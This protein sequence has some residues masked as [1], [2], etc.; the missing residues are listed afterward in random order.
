MSVENL[1]VKVYQINLSAGAAGIA[2]IGMPRTGES[3]GG[4][5]GS[6]CGDGGK[7]VSS[8]ARSR[9]SCLS[10][11]QRQERVAHG[12][13]A[14]HTV[15]R[16]GGRLPLAVACT[17]DAHQTVPP[18]L[19]RGSRLAGPRT[20]RRPGYFRQSCF[21]FRPRRTVDDP[22]AAT[23]CG[24]TSSTCRNDPVAEIDAVS[25]MFTNRGLLEIAIARIMPAGARIWRSMGPCL[26]PIIKSLGSP[27]GE[28]STNAIAA[29]HAVGSSVFPGCSARRRASR[30]TSGWAS[31]ASSVDTIH[32]TSPPASH[33]PRKPVTID[34]TFS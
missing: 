14:P 22:A 3:W 4:R 23:V 17:A 16:R 5:I 34:A 26:A 19:S 9:A 15:C 1:T 32:S 20:P 27:S 30:A 12:A 6:S 31:S 25:S 28:A 10:K 33:Q 2:S 29:R 24:L 8:R 21:G 11:N 7:S 18:L 13:S